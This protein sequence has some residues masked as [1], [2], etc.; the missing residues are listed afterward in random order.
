VAAGADG[1][2]V[3]LTVRIDLLAEGSLEMLTRRLALVGRLIDEGAGR[4]A[5]RP[6]RP[7]GQ[8]QMPRRRAA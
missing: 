5:A 8:E 1:L 6:A 7:A 2:G 4:D 3:P